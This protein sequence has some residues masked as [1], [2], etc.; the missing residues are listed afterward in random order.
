MLGFEA[1]QR[2]QEALRKIDQGLVRDMADEE[3]ILKHAKEF[4][5]G[6]FGAFQFIERE[7][8]QL[9]ALLVQL[10]RLDANQLQ[11]QSK[12]RMPFVLSLDPEVAYDTR[13]TSNPGQAGEGPPQGPVELAARV[14]VVFAP[15][16][17][18]MLRHYSIFADGLWKRTTFAFGHSG[19]QTRSTLLQRFGPDILV[20]EAADLLGH[21]CMLHPTWTNLEPRAEGMT[22]E[23]LRERSRVKEF[24]TAGSPRRSQ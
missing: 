7:T 8:L 9:N 18:G 3:A 11:I 10:K 5:D 24:L 21:V 17:Q 19:V 4:R 13:H 22:L 12:G 15:P 23:A 16:Y 14:F 2:A 1:Q 6:M 20:L